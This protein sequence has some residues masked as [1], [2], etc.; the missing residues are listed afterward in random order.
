M[1]K[2]TGSPVVGIPACNSFFARVFEDGVEQ[3]VGGFIVVRDGNEPK[4][5]VIAN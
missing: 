2:N 4:E 5:I 1:A 3:G